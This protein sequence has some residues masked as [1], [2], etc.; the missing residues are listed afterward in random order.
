MMM[1]LLKP[2]KRYNTYRGRFRIGDDP[3]RHEV[4]LG[5]ANKELAWDKLK[6]IAQ[7]AE[8]ERAGK[9]PAKTARQA[10]SRPLQELIEEF[11]AELH[12]RGRAP[13]YVRQIKNRLP[14][15]ARSCRWN[16]LRDI[17]PKAFQD[18][19]NRQEGFATRT[20]NHYLTALTAFLNWVEEIYGAPNLIRRRIKKLTVSA[21]YRE[22]PR[23]FSDEELS[24]LLTVSKKW[25]LLY[26]LLVSTGLRHMEA[27]KLQWSDVRF[28][29]Q[30]TLTLRP[31]ATKG[32]RWDVIP[33]CVD[34]ARELEAF[35]PPYWKPEM[36][37]FRRGVAMHT[38]LKEDLAKAGIPLE[39]EL[40]RPIGFHTFRRTFITRGQRAGIPPRIL[41]QLARHKSLH[42]TNEVYTDVTKLDLR[43][44]LEQVVNLDLKGPKNVW[45]KNPQVSNDPAFYPPKSGQ[46]GQSLSNGHREN[47]SQEVIS[48]LETVETES[49]SPALSTVVQV[50]QNPEKR[51]GRDSNPRRLAPQRISRPPQS[52]TLPPFRWGF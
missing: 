4:G 44:A 3:A 9:I 42:L 30:P 41:Q 26:Q 33:L 18:W 35:R 24:A 32:R 39:D 23:A 16:T 49:V 12:H 19:R 34:L 51:K 20:L 50:S 48:T 6:Q 1:Y 45:V 36:R 52:S 22:G 15:L 27:R 7:D 40:G 37:V 21:K 13:D 5:T 46:N 8:M 11:V 47:K 2:N 31:E 38:S 25:R 17:T 29:E 28:G 14:I 10:Q 43:G